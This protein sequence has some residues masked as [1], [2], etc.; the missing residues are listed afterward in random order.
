MKLKTFF[1]KIN[2]YTW[3]QIVNSG[4]KQHLPLLFKESVIHWDDSLGRE[5]VSFTELLLTYF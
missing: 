5:R 3:M 1:L 2:S 4:N